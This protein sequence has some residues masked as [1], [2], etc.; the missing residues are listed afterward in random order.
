MSETARPLGIVAAAGNLPTQ[1][2]SAAL[3]AGRE[4]FVF[5]LEGIV[6]ADLTPYPHA[7][8][9]LGQFGR[10]RRIAQERNI[11]DMVL[12]GAIHK[13]PDISSLGIDLGTLPLV[14]KIMK[15]LAA[16][17]DDAVLRGLIGLFEDAGFNVLGAHEV[18][19]SLTAVAGQVA[20]PAIRELGDDAALALKAA[21]GIG[22]LDIGQCAV[23]VDGRIIAV[24]AAEGTDAMIARVKHLRDIGRVRWRGRAGVLSKR[25]KPQQDLRVDMP[26][27]GPGTVEAVADAGLAGIVIEAGRVLIAERATTVQRARETATFIY[28]AGERNGAPTEPL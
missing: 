5:G 7:I 28:A 23:A 17:G 6:D 15:S 11:R 2:A 4:V 25:S 12:I 20:G 26:T 24:E 21:S 16:G 8:L 14:P 3:A 10:V 18:D 27:I 19:S 13:R 1:V 9:K 22:A